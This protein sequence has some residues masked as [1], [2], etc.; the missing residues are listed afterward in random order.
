MLL[1]N[2]LIISLLSLLS[3]TGFSQN[4][5]IHAGL[6]HSW[7]TMQDSELD[8]KYSRNYNPGFDLGLFYK[9]HINESFYLNSGVRYFR[10]GEDY[11]Y[12]FKET[13][14]NY[15]YEYRSE[16]ILSHYYLS[17]PIQLGYNIM[18]KFS[19]YVNIEP[20]IHVKGTDIGTGSSKEEYTGNGNHYINEYSSGWNQNI[21][22]YMNKFNLFMGVGAR[23]EFEMLQ[24]QFGVSGQMNFGLISVP[25][26]GKQQF[27]SNV[28]V[29]FPEWKTKE[30]SVT[31]EVYF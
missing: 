18:E 27:A 22:S 29:E 1:K 10:I 14:V 19:A 23:Y 13:P 30:I 6:T 16:G 31:A 8:K 26:K 2:I 4:L 12:S 11:S 15:I 28:T 9:Y 3:V 24:M 17:M 5:S 20:G 21:S 25:K 7:L